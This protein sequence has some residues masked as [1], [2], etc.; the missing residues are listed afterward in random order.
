MGDAIVLVPFQVAER[1]RAAGCQDVM[2]R[3]KFTQNL[4]VILRGAKL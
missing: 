2:P 1:G 3:P 4:P